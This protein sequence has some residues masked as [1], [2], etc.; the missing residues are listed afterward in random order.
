[1]Y[2][3]C[4]CNSILCNAS[5]LPGSGRADFYSLV[6]GDKKYKRY[7]LTRT[8]SRHNS[9]TAATRSC[10]NGTSTFLP[11]TSSRHHS[12]LQRCLLPTYYYYRY[13]IP[14]HIHCF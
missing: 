7:L 8:S 1:M 3:R 6:A 14:Y 12:N 2:R 11:G 5:E 13:P 9:L 4:L 10:I